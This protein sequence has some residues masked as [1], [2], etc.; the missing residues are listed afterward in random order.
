VVDLIVVFR[1][2]HEDGSVH[3]H[4]VVKLLV[5]SRFLLAKKTLADRD[6]LASHFSCSHSLL[7]SAVRYCHIA[8]P[9]K[10]DVDETPWIWTARWE[11]FA[12]EAGAV[13]DLFEKS[14]Q[15]FQADTWRKRREKQD[16]EASKA[17][18]KT[19]FTKLDFT[20]LVISKHLYSKD[21]LLAYMQEHGTA[22]MQLFTNKC[23]RK[24]EEF[25]EDAEEWA[26]ARENA[27]FEKTSDWDLLLQ[28][29]AK[30]CPH[31]FDCSYKKAV[32]EIFRL[33]RS[34]VCQAKLAHALRTI[35]KH[36]PSKH[37]RI[38]FLV[39]PSNSGKSTLL[40]PFDD[41][42][43]P[44]KV[45]H[46]PA[47]G[48]SFGLRNITKKRFFFWD[49][50]VPVEYAHEK[51]VPKSTFLSLFIGKHSEIQVSQSF[52]DGNLD[53]AWNRGVVFTAK[54]EGLWNT[55][56]RIGEEDVRH[57][58][59]RCDEYDFCHV[60]ARNSLQEVT[61]CAHHMAEWIVN[62]AVDYDAAAEVAAGSRVA[63]PL[64]DGMGLA[65]G[66]PE[67]ELVKGLQRLLCVA[68]IPEDLRLK[69]AADLDDLGA[70]DVVELG[71]EDWQALPSWGSL[72]TLQ[73]R[74]LLQL[75]VGPRA[76]P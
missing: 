13:V 36:G 58:Q 70:V 3:F 8:T 43:S 15:P 54:K 35:I 1:E 16:K 12:N 31:G 46:K 32:A 28:A 30:P 65:V 53:V 66:A 17:G 52:S 64:A 26:S 20:A 25:I 49:D 44:K 21:C 74:R 7:W 40:Y 5:Q 18:G 55:T 61:S 9:T 56:S 2:L 33:N 11:G 23:Q 48:S 50:Y 10:P 37:V 76:S 51:T 71:V 75:A 68:H 14:Q 19:S 38:P 27:L 47:L 63:L 67:T 69:L 45:L 57:M 42:Y 73:Q 62:G 41:L 29:L 60:F 24:L 4:V 39:G 22:T 6:R 72:R 59:N 34:T